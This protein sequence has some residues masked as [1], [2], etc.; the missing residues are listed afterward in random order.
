MGDGGHVTPRKGCVEMQ[1]TE[2]R[3]T[4]SLFKDQPRRSARSATAASNQD[5]PEKANVSPKPVGK[6]APCH[7][8]SKQHRLPSPHS[9]PGVSTAL[10]RA[11]CPF[12]VGA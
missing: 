2:D 1:E 7:P 11:P 10:R 9:L 8:S 6:D 5:R 3:G 12:S 4:H